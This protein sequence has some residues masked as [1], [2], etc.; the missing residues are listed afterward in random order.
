MLF[1]ATVLC[2]VLAAVAG[3]RLEALR[4]RGGAT[5]EKVA[6]IGSGNWGSAI[7]KIVGRNVLGTDQFE[8]DVHMWVFQEQVEGKNLTDIIN[9]E[10]ENVK[11]LPGIKF[12]DNVIADPD[13]AHA[14]EG[15]T[16]LIFVL[17]HQ[18][19][20]RICPQMTAMAKG[21][22]AIS[23]IKGIEFENGGPVLIS[24]MIKDAMNGMDVSVLMGANVANEVAQD[25]FCESTVGFKSKTNGEVWQ[26]LFNCP[27]FRIG[28]IDDV[29][30][31]ELCGALK[32]IVAIGAGFCDG[33]GYG[34]NTKA[35]I[36]RIGLLEM[37]KFANMFYPEAGVKD[38]TFLES[39][40]VADL[41]TTCFGGRNR[42]CAEAFAKH[43]KSKS[44]DEIEAELLGGQKLQGTLT[45][46]D[47]MT[48]LKEK[49]MEAEF[50]LFSRIYEIAF[51]G[52][53][54]GSIIEL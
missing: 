20:G 7:A 10:H 35:A 46:K 14:V 27:T 48:V 25:Q 51:E 17:P 37:K 4:M 49:K 43:G 23:L 54:C 40:G 18:F 5:K 36:M 1:R 16:L 28:T 26:K 30:G 45:A 21:C 9:S 41:I 31:V 29:A 11:Y 42:K 33:L 24:N 47:V 13:L 8:D 38:D 50:P 39:C 3:T 44:L 12:T 53:E 34:G 32:N 22:R 15:A 52:K 19:L 2:S 6:I